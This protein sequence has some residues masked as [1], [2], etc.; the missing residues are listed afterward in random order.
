MS[1]ITAALSE[2]EKARF[3]ETAR[4]GGLWLLHNQNAPGQAWGGVDASADTGRFIYE[5]YPTTGQCRAMGVWGQAL[6]V[7]GLS[8]LARVPQPDGVDFQAVADRAAGYLL[9]LQFLDSRQPHAVG[10][11]REQTPQTTW[12]Y[13]R[14]AATGC[15]ALAALYRQTGQTD[16]LERANLFCQWYRRFGSD[17]AGWP[18]N[19]FDFRTAQGTPEVPGDWQAGGSLAYYYTARAA[20]EPRWL[21]EGFRPVM[22]Q[23]LTIGDPTDGG[24][25]PHEWHGQCRLTTGNGDFSNIALVAAFRAFADERYLALLRRR[26]DLLLSLQDADGSLPNYGST[27][28]FALEGLDFLELA[29]DAG[30][31]DETDRLAEAVLRAARFGLTLQ[32]TTLRDVRAYG[33]FYGQ[34]SF[35][36]SRE[37]IHHRDTNYAIALYLRLAGFDAPCLSAVGW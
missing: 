7:C 26:L 9:S 37:R 10:A 16:Y 19:H 27:F 21:E 17:S 6:A 30:L 1:V 15:F 29:A 23:L 14:D 33:G 34:S 13:P 11:F 8:A 28:V 20:N 3:L 2:K 12:C 36:V 31:P 4:L 5:Y 35:G 22:E 24:Y 25:H 32:E 18:F